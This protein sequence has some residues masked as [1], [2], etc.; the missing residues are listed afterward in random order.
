MF[1]RKQN[2]AEGIRA[3]ANY[4]LV[5]SGNIIYVFP[6]NA[7]FEN[8]IDDKTLDAWA[9]QAVIVIDNRTGNTR[10]NRFGPVSLKNLFG[11]QLS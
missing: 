7:T 3:S 11:D 10:K 4:K 6:E 2:E 1:V 8:F 9:R 5:Q